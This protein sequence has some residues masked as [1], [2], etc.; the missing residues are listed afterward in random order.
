MSINLLF[1]VEKISNNATVTKNSFIFANTENTGIQ[2]YVYSCNAVYIASCVAD[3]A[4]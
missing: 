1:T 2:I 4:S 3:L